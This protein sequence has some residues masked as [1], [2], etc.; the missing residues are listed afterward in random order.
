MSLNFP[1]PLPF[2]LSCNPTSPFPSSTTH[3]EVEEQVKAGY[4]MPK[5]EGC[6]DVLYD[7][8]LSTWNKEPKKRPSFEHLKDVLE[9]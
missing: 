1:P 3:S 2:P 6:P 5:P 4:R 8:M 9:D 7:L